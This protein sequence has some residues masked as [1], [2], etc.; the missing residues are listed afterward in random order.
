MSK[1]TS[2]KIKT[3]EGQVLTIISK[4]GKDGADGYTPVKGID[5]FDGKD[6]ENLSNEKIIEL[7]K[8][9]NTEKEVEPVDYNKIIEEVLSKIPPIPV[10]EVDYES[11]KKF[12]FNEIMKLEEA[13]P[14]GRQLQSAGPTTSF[15]DISD[16]EVS[17]IQTGQSI[18]YNGQ[19]FIPYTPTESLSMSF[20]ETP[21]GSGTDF[22]LE[23]TP[24]NNSLR[25]YRGGAR[26]KPIED[27]TIDANN[28]TLIISLSIGEILLADYEY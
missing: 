28:I 25:L 27:Y 18:I 21:A 22:T 11:L 13:R 10:P 24:I 17:G 3:E 23:H 6:G 19:V 4:D 16:V 26:Q 14:R 5:Y 8:E 12:C 7:I 1:D 2:I 20:S 15:G 9:T